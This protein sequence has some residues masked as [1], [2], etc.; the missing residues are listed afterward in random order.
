MLINILIFKFCIE[1]KIVILHKIWRV[2]NLIIYKMKKIAIILISVFFVSLLTTSCKTHER[3][4]AYG[5]QKV[6]TTKNN[7][8]S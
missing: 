4:D 5:Y 2:L 6:D 7:R 8:P 1:K 3:C